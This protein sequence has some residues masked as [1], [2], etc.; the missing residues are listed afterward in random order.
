MRRRL[1]RVLLF[2]EIDKDHLD[3][4]SILLQILEDGRMTEGEGR[5][6]DFRNTVI[7]MTGNPGQS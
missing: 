4:F 5:T 3:G 2:D 6:V 1:Y 7:I